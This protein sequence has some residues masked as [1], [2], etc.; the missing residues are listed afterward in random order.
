MEK[1]PKHDNNLGSDF[2]WRELFI[3]ALIIF[4]KDS[5]RKIVLPVL[6]AI[7]IVLAAWILYLGLPLTHG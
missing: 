1:F 2:G 7:G 4:C 6:S 3:T 5:R